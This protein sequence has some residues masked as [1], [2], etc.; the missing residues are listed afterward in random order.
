VVS[1]ESRSQAPFSDRLA[2]AIA[3]ATSW[4]NIVT[5]LLRVVGENEK[6]T[7]RPFVYAFGYRL[8]DANADERR[9]MAGA[10]FGP[11]IDFGGE[12]LPPPLTDVA[13]ETEESW[14]EYLTQTDHPVALSRLHDLLWE[15][16]HGERHE[17][18][19]AA[20][21]SYLSLTKGEW[22]PMTRIVCAARALELARAI[23]DANC[24]TAAI[25]AYLQIADATIAGEDHL[26][27]VAL[28]ALVP[29][30]K[31][32]SA[33]RPE[34]L[35]EVVRSA[36]ERYRGDPPWIIQSL[37]ALLAGL[38]DP[39]EADTLWREQ[40]AD[41][42]AHGGA[43][44]GVLRYGYRQ[45]ALQL[46]LSHG[47]TDLADEIR[48]DIESMTADEFD[49]KTMSAEIEIP[50]TEVDTL[51]G[52]IAAAG[53]WPD[54]LRRLGA[55]GPP[56]GQVNANAAAVR[57]ADRT[58]PLQSVFGEQIIG[59][60]ASLVFRADTPERKFRLNMARQEGYGVGLFGHMLIRILERLV[61]DLGEPDEDELTR[62]LGSSLIDSTLARQC[63]RAFAYYWRGEYDAA[64]HLL[65]PRIEAI[66]RHLCLSLGN[67]V[68]K[69]PS[70]DKPGGVV[71]LALL[72]DRLEGQLDESWRRYLCHALT[73]PLGL[74]LRNRISH[75][76]LH[77]VD[78]MQVALLMHV[79][80]FLAVLDVRAL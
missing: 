55:Q 11:M 71:T 8:I 23:N 12:Q 75:G 79:V 67:Q 63:A 10:P 60:H 6:E 37:T 39:P 66:I 29:L 1:T 77:E 56:S 57:D 40:V 30:V 64:G 47:F 74:N 61:Q 22:D 27:G 32:P 58:F 80:L 78:R 42:L 34:Q 31:L 14:A 44:T 49:F 59:P 36:R 13:L 45:D 41:L 17:H 4:D 18:A 52:W 68:T 9:Q 21:T 76:L 65:A 19:R 62:C 43:A 51:V 50:A 5:R 7:A 72:L 24:I 2:S 54:A 70:G 16:G 33:L 15:R 38:V 28:H 73:D 26:P 53:D 35:V 69:L 48:R 25:T 3:E 20:I 46:A